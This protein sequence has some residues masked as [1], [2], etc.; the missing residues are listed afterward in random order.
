VFFASILPLL[1]L[2]WSRGTGGALLILFGLYRALLNGCQACRVSLLS[3]SHSS[4]MQC[5]AMQ[6]N[7]MQRNATQ[8]N[9]MQRNAVQCNAMQRNAMQCSANE[10]LAS[11]NKQAT[12]SNSKTESTWMIVYIV[13]SAADKLQDAI[14]ESTSCCRRRKL[15]HCEVMCKHVS[16]SVSDPSQINCA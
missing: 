7:A 8:C 10:S 1:F 3:D 6:C 11:L 5:N 16:P 13:M 4:A 9:A 14:A 12:H 2:C 15:C